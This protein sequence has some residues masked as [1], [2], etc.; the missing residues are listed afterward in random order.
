MKK[1]SCIF[2]LLLCCFAVMFSA[3]SEGA[4]AIVIDTSKAI[5]RE[6]TAEDGQSV[7]EVVI[8]QGKSAT[9]TCSIEEASSSKKAKVAWSSSDKTIATVSQ[10]KI[11]GKSAGTAIITCTATLADG[12]EISRS[13][14][15]TVEI[16]VTAL[17]AKT[18]AVTVNVGETAEAV[19]VTIAPDDAT[20][21][22]IV[23][24]SAD[25]T[26]AAVDEKG[27]ITGIK[28]GKTK[29]TAT[30]G[31]NVAKPK[32]V[33]IPVTV[34]QPV[35][36]VSFGTTEAEI[37]KGKTL[38]L[39]ASVFPEDSSNKK[40]TWTSAD[41][42]IAT[43]ANGV[44]TAKSAGT[45]TITCTATDGSE[46]AATC[47]V[48]VFLP[49]TSVA[50]ENKNA[51]TFVGG[52]SITLSASVKPNDAKYTALT[53]SSSD[54]SIATVDQNGVVTP[55]KAGK[56]T[57]T[58]TANDKIDASSKQK[59]AKC[60]VKVDQP[61]TGISIDGGNQDVA[62]GKTLKLKGNVEPADATNTKISWSTSDAEIA[63][64]SN[65]MVT[66]KKT[67]EVTI[68]ATA[69]DGSGVSS[70]VKIRVIQGVTAVKSTTKQLVLFVGQEGKL[71]ASVAPADATIKTVKWSSEYQSVA[72]VDQNGKVT[73]KRAGTTTIR[74]EATDGSGKFAS[75]KVYVE[76][77]VPLTLEGLGRGIYMANLLGITVEN[78]CTKTTIVNFSFDMTIT[79]YF[80]GSKSGS[81]TLGD[82]NV[83][84]GPGSTKKIKRNASGVA[85][86]YKVTITIT[87]VTLKD[88]T[89]YAIPDNLQDTWTFT[90]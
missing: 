79:S 72:S 60:I 73:A 64:V 21:Q 54:E 53:W 58:A 6:V 23:W 81:Y 71:S 20:C 26:I 61:V 85:S 28:V 56:V 47:T 25:E 57:I 32:S 24:S 7:T 45:T 52:E 36:T 10:G 90:F 42:K 30:S 39:T 59:T 67:G 68:I 4:P 27:Q 12:T 5:V 2:A 1:V 77:A 16:G 15:A 9:L 17:K 69:A 82:K 34:L 31:E 38:K 84:I 11:T 29:I 41:T 37:A 49:V 70:S 83:T 80:G 78:H 63:T 50:F 19:D 87:G 65:G 40:L 44:V 13:I 46:A 18:K 3:M 89:Y 14:Q 51:T 55:I 8:F 22:T 75:I 86:A 74:A 48:E 76:P 88:G 43:V 62:K 66:G 35:Q 33:A